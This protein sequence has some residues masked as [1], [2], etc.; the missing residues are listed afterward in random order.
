MATLKTS[1]AAA[2]LKV[3]PNT[4][5]AW[6]RRFGYPKP[7]R[8]PGKNRLYTYGEIASLRDALNE[9]LSIGAAI[10]R[11]REQTAAKHYHLQQ[12]LLRC[13]ARK[14]DATLDGVLA[15]GSVEQ[16]VSDQILP[17]L[18]EIAEAHGVDSAA[19]GCGAMWALD[20][21]ARARRLSPASETAPLALLVIGTVGGLSPMTVRAFALH[22]MLN[23]EG[24]RVLAVPSDSTGGARSLITEQMP[25]SLILAGQISAVDE[26][27]WRDAMRVA[28]LA[29]PVLT[30]GEDWDERDSGR[31]PSDAEHAARLV[32]QFFDRAAKWP[33]EQSAGRG[34]TPFEVE[35]GRA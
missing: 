25:A 19:W 21:L 7:R 28:I 26:R 22:L 11:V 10:S 12:A 27:A 5:R 32:A 20:W 17:V 35:R 3:S 16:A 29:G 13:D 1:E 4:L 33:P 24:V 6:E 8:A 14:A 9:G 34:V 30:F 31:L 15:M 2:V 23:R 18:E